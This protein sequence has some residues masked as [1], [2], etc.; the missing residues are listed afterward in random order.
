MGP[1]SQQRL[2]QIHPTLAAK[3][4]QLEKNLERT[5]AVVQGL[6]TSDEQGAL[7][8]QGRLSLSSVNEL[9][10]KV[11]WSPLSAQQNIDT[12]THAK[13]GQSY[14]EFGM[15]VDIAPEDVDTR[16]LDWNGSHPIWK[17]MIEKGEALGLTSGVSWRD[18]P[19]FQL[20]GKW[21]LNKPPDE[22]KLLLNTE[23]LHAVWLA[24]GI[25]EEPGIEHA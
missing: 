1:V 4:V 14:H 20:T 13:P 12:V 6:R 21:P 7:F 5:I 8:A 3:I 9:R 22:A 2:T 23:G 10:V 16:A 19:H 11:G 24:A 18:E 17:E 25:E 15:A